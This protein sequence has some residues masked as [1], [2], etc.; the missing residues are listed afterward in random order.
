MK[1]GTELYRLANDEQAG[2]WTIAWRTCHELAQAGGNHGLAGAGA[3][4]HDGGRGIG[5]QTV[6]KEL[7]GDL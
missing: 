4:A 7:L 5:C 3:I 2:L 1:I 6:H